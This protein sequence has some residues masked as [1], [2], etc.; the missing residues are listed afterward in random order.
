MTKRSSLTAF[1]YLV[2]VFL[3][4][5]L[6]GVFASRLYMVGTVRSSSGHRSPEEYRRRYIEE[7]SKRLRL[8]TEQIASL[9]QIMDQTRQRYHDVHERYRPELKAI[10]DEQYQKVNGIL[11]AAQRA[12]YEKMRQERERRRQP[13]PPGR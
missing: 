10:E 12:E 1:A 6:V 4:G 3:S 8:S 11:A 5:T 13:P 9:Q 2:V 7:M